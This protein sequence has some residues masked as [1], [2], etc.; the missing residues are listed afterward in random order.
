MVKGVK[1]AITMISISKP[2]G[3]AQAK[4]YL[5]KESYYQQNSVLG[6]WHG[7]A[8][9]LQYVGLNDSD[10]IDKKIYSSILNGIHPENGKHLLSNS[11]SEKRRAGIDI[12]FSAPKS[13][14]LLMELSEGLGE[15]IFEERIRAAHEEAVQY[16]MDKVAQYYVKTRIRRGRGKRET[17]N[18]HALWA[19]F[20]HDTTRETGLGEIDPQ[21]HTHNFMMALTFYTDPLTGKLKPYAMSNEEIYTNKMYLGQ[22]YRNALAKNLS[23]IGLPIE[24][25]NIDQGFFELKGFTQEQLDAFSGRRTELLEKLA[26]SELKS[27]NRAKLIDLINA[28][29]KKHKRKIDRESLI[30]HNQNRMRQAGMGRSFFNRIVSQENSKLLIPFLSKRDKENLTLEHL[31]KSLDLLEEQHSVFGYEEIMKNTLKFGLGYG[32]ILQDYHMAFEEIMKQGRLI[33]LDEN[34]YSTKAIVEAEKNVIRLMIEGK[35]SQRAYASNDKEVD[36]FIDQV[37]NNM[38]K[39]QREM[40]G[41][42]LGTQDQFIAVQGDAGTG[43]TYAASAIKN[44]MALKNQ[45]T[46]VIGLSF[47][48]KAAQSLEEESGIASSTLHSFIYKEEN[49]QTDIPKRRLILVDEAGMAGSLQISKLM[50]I[51]KRNNDKVV[52]IG[53]TKQFSSIAAGNIFLDMQ[54][55]GVQTVY[56]SETMR[57]KSDHAKG[58]VKAVKS[59]QIDKVVEILEKRGSF[60]EMDRQESIEEIAQKY[61]EIYTSIDSLSDEL[62]IASMNADRI[63]INE[64]IR[65]HLEKVGEGEIY[66]VKESWSQNGVGRYFTK[67]LEEGMLI[68][69]SKVPGT[70]NGAEYRIGTIIDDKHIEIEA[71][72]GK[73]IMIDFYRYSQQCQIYK[74]VEKEFTSGDTIVFTKNAC[75]EQKAKVKNGERAVIKNIENGIIQTTNGKRIDIKEMNYLDYGYAITDYKSQ[76]ATTKNVTI[77]ADTQMASLNSFYTQVTRAKDNITVYTDNK[78]ALLANLK[79]DARQHSTLEYTMRGKE[80]EEKNKIKEEISKAIRGAG[81]ALVGMELGG[82]QAA[83]FLNLPIKQSQ[84]SSTSTDTLFKSI[85]GVIQK[86][87]TL[88]NKLDQKS[89]DMKDVDPVI[90]PVLLHPKEVRGEQSQ[91]RVTIKL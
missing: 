65:Q 66:A 27:D 22:L 57:Q 40:V 36:G 59:R 49:K 86:I 9:A 46:E 33:K 8:Q 13:V 84:K 72:N 25:T 7:S 51:A 63:S 58:I 56:M 55:Y 23:D 34:V 74:E 75:L 79:K 68:I 12:T 82:E 53:D 71:S 78:E 83:V 31:Q 19:S 3:A 80:I 26:N 87:D 29:T 77:C 61:S 88:I 70:K 47:T 1:G 6:Q 37:Y 60:V 91:A 17:V 21:L 11:A 43:K 85:D 54:T 16:A 50:K 76:G 14:S 32:F 42:V 30:V 73:S 89:K 35:E 38:T 20:Q 67:S 18:T 90:K 28:K 4:D 52:F 44:F 15:K 45:S 41:C 24:V 62:I 2:Q 48:G 64:S 81:T 10:S 39:G 69:P 5:S